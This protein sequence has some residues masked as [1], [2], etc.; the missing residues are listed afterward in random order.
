MK[1]LGYI[2]A[3]YENSEDLKDHPTSSKRYSKQPS[4][5]LPLKKRTGIKSSKKKERTNLYLD[6][7]GS[8]R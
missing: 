5:D 2:D 4:K 6:T 3:N 1:E 7:I 8:N